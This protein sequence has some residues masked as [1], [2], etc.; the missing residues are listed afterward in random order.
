MTLYHFQNVLGNSCEDLQQDSKG[1]FPE[2]HFLPFHASMFDHFATLCMKVLKTCFKNMLKILLSPFSGLW[3]KLEKGYWL[4][5]EISRERISLC[6]S[7]SES[8]SERLS[9]LFSNL[10]I[11]MVRKLIYVFS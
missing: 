11:I 6:S 10:S 5:F 4:L 3:L 8:A 7:N 2:A 1:F 9:I